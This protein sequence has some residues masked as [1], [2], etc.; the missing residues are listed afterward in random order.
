MS[1]RERGTY[2]DENFADTIFVM[3]SQQDKVELF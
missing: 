2:E 3:V 1:D